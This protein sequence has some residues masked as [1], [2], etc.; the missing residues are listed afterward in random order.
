MATK[1]NREPEYQLSRVE[2]EILTVLT[3]GR[4]LYGLEIITAVQDATEGRRRLGFGSLYPTLHK[5]EKK[6]F[7]KS[8][9]G[10]E[11]PEERGGARRKYYRLTALGQRALREA[12]SV[13]ERLATW[14]PSWGRA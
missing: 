11:K 1:R 3:G 5:L 10:E 9:W 13:R 12:A 6:G 8:E 2:E 14:E 7:L 4:S